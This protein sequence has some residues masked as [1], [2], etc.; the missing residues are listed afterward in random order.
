M[1][2]EIRLRKE[3]LGLNISSLYFGGGTPSVLKKSEINIILEA[4]KSTVE[5]KKN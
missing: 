3:E 4:I 2:E 5:F 1:V